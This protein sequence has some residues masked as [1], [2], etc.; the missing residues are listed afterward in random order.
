MGD[1]II[2]ILGTST[3]V[4]EVLAEK[5]GYVKAAIACRVFFYQQ[6]ERGVCDACIKT[7][8]KK[9]GM[10]T[11]TISTNLKWL[12]DNEYIEEIGEHKKGNVR[13]S[14]KV[15]NKFYSAVQH[16]F[17]ERSIDQRSGDERNVQEMNVN[18]QEMNGKEESKEDLKDS[19]TMDAQL[20]EIDQLVK[21]HFADPDRNRDFKKDLQDT[22]TKYSPGEI[23]NAIKIAISPDRQNG[24]GKTWGYVKGI[25]R[26]REEKNGNRPKKTTIDDEPYFD[27]Q[28]GEYVFPDGQRFTSL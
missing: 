4:S 23:L 27:V 16:S 26:K 10:S 19:T 25:L 5:L 28:T 9:L 21:K 8:A 14:Y 12:L 1:S 7:L 20:K 6:L 24:K 18:V 2:S 22:I 13:N 11:G 17:P 15:T 3:P